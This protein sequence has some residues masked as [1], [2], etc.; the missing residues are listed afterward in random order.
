MKKS[1]LVKVVVIVFVVFS[2]SCSN[3]K[4]P[5]NAETTV[6]NEVDTVV[7]TGTEPPQAFFINENRFFAGLIGKDSVFIES[8]PIEEGWRWFPIIYL[9]NDVLY[10][11]TDRDAFLINNN[12]DVKIISLKNVSY[13]FLTLVDVPFSD[14]WF[15][16]RVYEKRVTGTFTVFKDFLCDFDNDGFFEVGG[17]EIS[18]SPCFTFGCDSARYIPF[19]IFKLNETFEF[20]SVVSKK[21]TMELY[22]TFLGFD[23]I[24]TVLYV[25][26]EH[27]ISFFKKYGE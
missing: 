4:Q 2:I 6:S 23:Y 22:D 13:I 10:K 5:T 19:E 7:I 12:T 16:L 9:E 3:R 26:R 17:R 15:V 11:N 20:D 14:K 21:L 1:S 8:E 24:D 18:E 25:N 27:V